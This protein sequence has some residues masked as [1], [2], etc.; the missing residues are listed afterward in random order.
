M[1]SSWEWFCGRYAGVCR[2]LDGLRS[3]VAEGM[4]RP[5][6]WAVIACI[7]LMFAF[8]GLWDVN[9]ETAALA[10][11]NAA[12]VSQNART[13]ARQEAQAK[14]LRAAVEHQCKTDAAH[15]IAVREFIKVTKDLDALEALFGLHFFLIDTT[16]CREVSG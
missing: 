7:G 10:R 16:T 2:R 15:D 3:W 5:S 11:Q 12:L 6:F 9:R 13:N 4:R 1:R 8:A 14:E